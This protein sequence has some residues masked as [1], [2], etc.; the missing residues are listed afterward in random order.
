MFWILMGILEKNNDEDWVIGVVNQVVY[1]GFEMLEEVIGV[2]NQVV[3]AGF[4]VLEEVIDVVDWVVCT[5]FDITGEMISESKGSY[6]SFVL[7][8]QE[9]WD[10]KNHHSSLYF[11]SNFYEFA[12]PDV[13]S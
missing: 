9:Y 5:G 4:K 8:P 3:C 2:V 10:N 11:D 13:F 7:Y 6:S 1:V 12:F